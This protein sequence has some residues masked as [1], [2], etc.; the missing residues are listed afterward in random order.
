MTTFPA[1]LPTAEQFVK[2]VPRR[3]AGLDGIESPAA[4]LNVTVIVSPVRR[5]P[6]LL[7][8]N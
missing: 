8:L 5:L 6:V 7:S 1:V 2:P 3:I 4:A